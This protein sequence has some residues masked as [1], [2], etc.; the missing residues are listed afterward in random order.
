MKRDF[1]P[2]PVATGEGATVFKLKDSRFRLHK[3]KKNFYNAGSETLEQVVQRSCACPILGSVQSE[4]RWGFEQPD[5]LKDVP[6]HG[7]GDWTKQSLKAPSNPNHSMI[8]YSTIL[9]Y[10]HYIF[11]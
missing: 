2:Q 10:I 11:Q 6:A 9:A 5:L 1:L 8:L 4:V 7:T 3:R